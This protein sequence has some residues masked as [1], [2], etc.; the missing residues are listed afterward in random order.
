MSIRGKFLS[1]D[2]RRLVML[3][4]AVDPRVLEP[5]V[6]AGTELDF[7]AGRTYLS[8]IGFSFEKMNVLGVPAWGLR[9]FVEVNL[10][11][12]VVRRVGK[13]L[14]RGVTFVREIAPSRVLATAARLFYGEQY[15][16]LPTGVEKIQWNGRLVPTAGVTYQWR[17]AGRWHRMGAVARA[18]AARPSPGSLAEFI[19]EHYWGY[20]RLSADRSLEYQVEHPPW[21]VADAERF[22]WDCDAKA[23]YG[24]PW[25]GVLGA[26]DSA[27]LVDGSGVV[28]R[29]PTR[30][31]AAH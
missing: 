23:V 3:N 9:N 18:S 27:L 22:D 30:I 31:A 15:R 4:F 1:A 6:P 14:R 10:R 28:V 12:Y 24:A 25:S 29:R 17:C 5:H 13:E 7:F 26:P 16:A 11:F 21:S 19:V 8:V 20:T 2:W